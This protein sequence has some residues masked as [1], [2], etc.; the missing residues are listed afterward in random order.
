MQ[1]SYLAGTYNISRHIASTQT[2]RLQRSFDVLIDL[3]GQIGLQKNV[4]KTVSISCQ[5]FRAIVGHSAE[6]YG[7]HMTW[8]GSTYR[9]RLH[10]NVCFP[11]CNMYLEV[12]SL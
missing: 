12:G 5:L 4:G 10:H 1:M 6:A 9:E 2:S 11:E 7:I 8:E 3:F